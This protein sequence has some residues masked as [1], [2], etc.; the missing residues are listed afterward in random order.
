MIN[1]LSNNNNS[2]LIINSNNQIANHNLYEGHSFNKVV[3]PSLS[4]GYGNNSNKNLHSGQQNVLNNS[5]I[6]NSGVSNN[7]SMISDSG[8]TSGS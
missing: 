4:K 1:G 8:N 5:G 6:I 7:F 3:T 2:G